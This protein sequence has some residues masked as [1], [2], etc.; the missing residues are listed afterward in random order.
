MEFDLRFLVTMGG[1]IASVGGS[2]AVV[3]SQVERL[4]KDVDVLGNK[5]AKLDRRLD[6]HAVATSNYSPRLDTQDDILSP[7]ALADQTRRIERLRADVD[8]LMQTK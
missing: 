5:I 3:R 2:F 4:R 6:Q 8:H 7:T 1:I